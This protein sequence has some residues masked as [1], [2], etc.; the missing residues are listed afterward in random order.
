MKKLLSCLA[1]LSLTLALCVPTATA[2][3][4]IPEKG[5]LA[6]EV[7]K[8][9]SY[10]LLNG[11]SPSFFGYTDSMTRAQFITVMGRMLG[12][13]DTPATLTNYIT[14]EMQVAPPNSGSP[15]ATTS[16]Y[17]HAINRAA[18]L[19]VV[20]RMV[21]FR[22]SDPITRGEMAEMLVRGLGLKSAAAILEKENT[23]P[24][25]DLTDR[26]GYVAVAYAIGMTKGTSDT[27]FSPDATATRAQAA[28]MLVRIYEKL[29]RETT[30]V[31]GFYA[32]SSYSQLEL[33]DGMD[34]VSSGWS[35]MIWDGEEVLLSTTSANGNE[36]YIPT[37]YGEVTDFLQ[38]RQVPL[39]LNVFMDAAKGGR[40]LLASETGRTQAVEEIIHELTV[41]YN[42]I[43]RNPYSGVTIDFESL[44]AE[45]KEDFTAFLLELRSALDTIDKDLFV[46]V[47]PVLLGGAWY[48][49]YDYR[50]IGEIADKV[51]LMAYDY[52][53]RDMSIYAGTAIRSGSVNNGYIREWFSEGSRNA[54]DGQIFLSLMAISDPESGVGDL[55][56]VL[57]G[58]SSKNVA[59]EVD[60]NDR[61]VS[62]KPL[63]LSND[64]AYRYIQENRRQY[65]SGHSYVTFT[66]DSGQRC[67]MWLE[68][69]AENLRS[70]KL[71]GIQGISLWRLGTLP[72]Y[73]GWNW[74][75]L[76]D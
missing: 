32:L 28:A 24:F 58:V 33:A 51:I 45:Q 57:L 70:A 61:L 54:P 9:I 21:P 69:P 62:G 40:E 73:S 48:D 66:N 13:F 3:S 52:E 15:Y 34:A 55:S 35:R 72:M 18:E 8:S 41:S 63:Y 11:Y 67:F 2:Y 26:L 1:A 46:C 50:A 14:G 30:F 76:L 36:Y 74:N 56:K 68:N 20:D 29:N 10:G 59:W 39:H 25:T 49:G 16:T 53:A 71:L 19:D 7:R 27:T 22:P 38:E 64:T 37:G 6:G 65:D 17:Y 31:H 44:R 4:D 47:S 60:E 5:A 23:L 75:E 43:G 42:A 12:W